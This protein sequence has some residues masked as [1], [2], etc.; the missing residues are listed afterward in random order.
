MVEASNRDWGVGDRI[1]DQTEQQRQDVKDVRGR[2]GALGT[3]AVVE[4]EAGR[5]AGHKTN[6]KKH[7]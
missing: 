6:P 5:N 2:G 4:K 1:D 3:G 7:Y